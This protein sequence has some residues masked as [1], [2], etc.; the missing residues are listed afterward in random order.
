MAAE[1]GNKSCKG[2]DAHE[3]PSI[4]CQSSR[5]SFIDSLAHQFSVVDASEV[6][7]GLWVRLRVMLMQ[8]GLLYLRATQGQ[9]LTGWVRTG[10]VMKVMLISR[11]GMGGATTGDGECHSWSEQ[12]WAGHI[13]NCSA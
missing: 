12:R 3:S 11:Q 4:A 8:P 13:R 5:E 1:P 2:S 10:S 6:S 7:L 9:V